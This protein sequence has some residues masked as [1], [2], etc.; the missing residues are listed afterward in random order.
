[1][2]HYG[3]ITKD[4]KKLL[5]K[6][7]KNGKKFLSSGPEQLNTVQKVEEFK[8]KKLTVVT[9]DIMGESWRLLE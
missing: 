1:M 5:K 7:S 3:W 8:S 9:I 2:T 4:L 6:Q